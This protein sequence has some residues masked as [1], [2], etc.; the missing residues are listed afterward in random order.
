MNEAES[1]TV[2]SPRRRATRDH[3]ALHSSLEP[4]Q[5]APEERILW[6]LAAEKPHLQRNFFE[7]DYQDL[8]F[9]E[10]ICTLFD[11][12]DLIENPSWLAAVDSISVSMTAA[13]DFD[14]VKP[15]Q[16]SKEAF[17]KNWE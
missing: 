16:R 10:H 15:I 7:L 1:P 2:R 14:P 3:E 6:R 13:W 4:K 12:H 5:L 17:L 11:F 9:A 8:P